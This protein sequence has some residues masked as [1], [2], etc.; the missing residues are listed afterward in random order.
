MACE[1]LLVRADRR[2]LQGFWKKCG[3]KKLGPV[4]WQ[5]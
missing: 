4:G 1:Q 5:L 3:D 2:V